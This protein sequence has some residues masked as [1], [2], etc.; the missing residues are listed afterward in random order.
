MS[1]HSNSELKEDSAREVGGACLI[2]FGKTVYSGVIAA[3]GKSSAYCVTIIYYCNNAYYCHNITI[4][5]CNNCSY[6]NVLFY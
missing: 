5:I 1:V 6:I 2:N 4:T 3:A